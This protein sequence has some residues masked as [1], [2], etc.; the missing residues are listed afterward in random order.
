MSAE[1]SNLYSQEDTL[2]H[3]VRITTSLSDEFL[4]ERPGWLA[5]YT[6][7]VAQKALE[8][9]AVDEAIAFEASTVVSELAQNAVKH[10]HS[11]DEFDI[12]HF[13]VAGETVPET[14]YVVT[15]NP[16]S[17]ETETPGTERRGKLAAPEPNSSA[18]SGRG[19]LMT[20]VYT[21]HN[22]GQRNVV[23]PTGDRKI[24]TF[25]VLSRAEEAASQDDPTHK[26][27]A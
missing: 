6:R 1:R 17:G 18:Q 5:N 25:A 13:P 12:V 11:L 27:A 8:V 10:G 24:V 26:H 16:A 7:K 14:V 9:M 19:L 2:R 23:D 15:V 3:D 22:W 21:N 4:S 20:D